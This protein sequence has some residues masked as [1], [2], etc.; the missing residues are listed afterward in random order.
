M[1]F[2]DNIKTAWVV[3]SRN[4]IRSFLT[5]LGII[6]GIMA[7]IVIISVGSGAQSLILNQIKGMGSDLV[8]ILPG[9][10]N[11][12][13]PPASAMGIVITSLNYDDIKK[14]VSEDKN[15][16]AG[17]VYVKGAET[18]NWSYNKVDTT[19]VGTNA[20]YTLVE[21]TKVDKG[22]FFSEA[23]EK[24]NS[25]VAVLGS[26]VADELFNGSDPIG[27]VIK[28]K[29]TNF[30]V[31][32]VM[33]KRG[34]SGFQNQDD[35]IFVPVTTAQKLLLGIDHVSFARIKIVDPNEVGGSMD[36]I[37]IRLRE[38]H[39]ID[40]PKND[41][42]SVRSMAQGLEVFTKV[43]DVLRIFLASIAGIALV[44]GGIG[45]MNI[46]LAAVQER[47]REIGL[48][49]AVGA[50]KIQIMSQFLIETVAITFIGGL[51][52]IILGVV[53]SIIVAKVAQ[54]MGYQWDL[55]VSVFSIGL[56]TIVSVLVGLVFGLVPARRAS[57]L[58]PIE[59]LRYE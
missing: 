38:L 56:A 27:Q 16:S 34:V 58:N 20:D 10:A 7:V 17:A 6:I 59:A 26:L 52:G 50:K 29:K 45:I 51:I 57:R 3:L 2:G 18:I 54:Y 23:D 28:I 21:D 46:M 43:T 39:N 22:R 11:E 25:R 13:G 47:T 42:F 14:I 37:K 55:I 31:I 5:M 12:D 53:I 36:Y 8:G 33:R 30:N 48:R 35:Q 44:V 40:N 9:K 1:Q 49:K 4:K 19:F 32:G 41:D 15:I 24:S